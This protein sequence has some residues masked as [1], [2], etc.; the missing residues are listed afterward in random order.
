[1]SYLDRMEL[2]KIGLELELELGWILVGIGMDM[3]LELGWIWV[4]IGMDWIGYGLG[5]V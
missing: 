2:G 1:M 4:G 3:G 5:W